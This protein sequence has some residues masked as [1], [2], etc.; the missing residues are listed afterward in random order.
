MDIHASIDE[1]L[2]SKQ[3]SITHG[4]YEW[5]AGFLSLFDTWIAEQ[6][7]SDLAHVTPVHVQQ[8]VSASPTTNTH[9]RHAR[10][11][12]V[13]GF[14]NWCAQDEEMGVREKTIKRILM[15]KMEESELELFTDED[16]LKLFKACDK[17]K[18]PHRNRAILH[19]LLDTGI[20]ASELCYDGDRPEEETG[21]RMEHVILGRSDESF[22]RV[23]GKGRK[24]RT[25]GFG[26]ETRLAFQRYFNRE[27]G[28]AACTYVFL[29]QGN[30]R[31]LS[32]KRLG[33]QLSVLGRHAGVEHV[34][35]HRFRHTFAV[36][37]LMNGTSDLVL[38][39]LMGHTSLESTKIY[40]RAMSQMQAR[41]AAP[42]VVDRMKKQP[43]M[44]M[45]D[46]TD[47]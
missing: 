11:Q 43:H 25:V 21:L 22:I 4:T 28:R 19:V 40:T 3:N 7:I 6:G 12:I 23:M 44:R 37:Q 41:K 20:R 13:K 2:G 1:Y 42:S 9:T 24:T 26:N 36:N 15:P 39:K 14:L 35:P 34:Y 33:E 27:R 16:I 29:A 31:Q 10:A 18:H 8:F 45:N 46:R 5:Y 47:I 32:V 38:M 17:T 30:E